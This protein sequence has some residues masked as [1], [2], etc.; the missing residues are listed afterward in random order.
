MASPGK[1]FFNVIAHQH[2]C[3]MYV[4]DM[5]SPHFFVFFPPPPPP[6]PPCCAMSGGTDPECW[7]RRRTEHGDKKSCRRRRCAASRLSIKCREILQKAYVKLRDFS[8][9]SCL[10]ALPCLA[11]AKQAF[12][13]TSVLKGERELV[14]VGGESEGGGR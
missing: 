3:S 13:F 4:D 14:W 9:C 2:F 11:P 10:A 6:P 8:S 5:L 12:L 1:Y 7:R